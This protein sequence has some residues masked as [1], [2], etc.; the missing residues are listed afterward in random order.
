MLA[1]VV[2]RGPCPGVKA[3][4]N[5]FGELAVERLTRYLRATA[6]GA[7]II[8]GC[9]LSMTV[10]AAQEPAALSHVPDFDAAVARM[11]YPHTEA[12]SSRS[13]AALPAEAQA[14]TYDEYQSQ[15][16]QTPPVVD[17]PYFDLDAYLADSGHGQC[18]WHWQLLPNDLIYKSYLAGVKEPRSGT[19]IT[20]IRGDGWLWRGILGARIGLLRFGDVHPTYPQGFQIDAEGAAHVRLDVN[21][22]FDLRSADYRVGIPVTYGYGR[23]QLKF[24]YYHMSSHLGD[25][26]LLKNPGIDR[27]NWS[28][29]A[30]VLGHSMYLTDTLRAYGEV[31]WAFY[32]D[33]SEPW[34]FQFGLDW[35][36]NAPT[37]FRGAPFLAANGHLR[38][39]VDFGGNLSFMAGWA[40]VSDR[41]RH[42]LRM[43]LHYYDG[44]SNQYSFFNNHESQIGAGVWYDF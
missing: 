12:D 23:H 11:N 34:E 8:L 17:Q 13:G 33:V 18:G 35:A 39:E 5:G 25:E 24:A 2:A 44:K 43:G 1:V 21:D 42:L 37:G 32:S 36:P 16:A 4:W 3:K 20:N 41:D 40:W 26:F 6:F 7:G 10:S 9:A 19:T 31:G 29:D 15:V 14:T 27:L 22:D 38:Q 28:R 30:F